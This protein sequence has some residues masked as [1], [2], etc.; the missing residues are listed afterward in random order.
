MDRFVHLQVAGAYSFLWGTFTP[1]ALVS[2]VKALGQRAVA[3]TDDGLYGAVRFYKAARRAGIQPIIGGR[4]AYEPGG[5]LTLLARD[6]EGY[7]HLCRMLSLS[8]GGSTL[9]DRP[10]SRADLGRL[11]RGLICLAGG[12]GT[13]LGLFIERG[14][15]EAAR[16]A[17]LELRTVFRGPRELF[18]VVQNYGEGGRLMRRSLELASRADLPPVAT[19]GVL[20]LERGDYALHRVLVRIQRRHHHREVEP[21]P[22]DGFYLAS[23]ETMGRL[24]PEAEALANTWRIAEACKGFSL[25]TGRLHPPRVSPV[26]KDVSA[27]LGRM[28]FKELAGRFT[29]TAPDYILQLGRELEVIG[30][31]DLADFFLLVKGVVDFAREAG[32]RHSVRGSAAGSLVVHLLL[33]GVDPVENDLLFE[34]FINDGRGDMPDV[35]IDFDSE[36]RDEVLRHVMDRFAG[37]AAMVCTVGKFRSR[38]AVRLVARGLGYSLSEI[39]RLSECLPY[40]IRGRDLAGALENLPELEN[41]PLRDHPELVDLACRLMALP[42]QPSVHLGGVIIAPGDIEAWTPLGVSNKGFAV[43]QFDKNDVDDLGLLKLDLLGLRM[44]TAVG[45]AVEVLRDRGIPFDP[46]RLPLD[47]SKTYAL[48]Q[49]THSLGVF[50]VESPGQRSLLG[51]MAPRRFS[52]LVAEISLFRPGPVEGNMVDVYVRRRNRREPIGY[53]DPVLEPILAETYGVILFQ[54][55]VL[56]VVNRFAGLSYADADVFRRAM[57]KDRGS[58][59]MEVLRAAFLKGASRLGRDPRVAREVF[60]HVAAFAAYGFCKAHAASFAHITYQSAYLK[61]HY[62]LAFYIGLLNAGHVGSYPAYVIL[63]EARR[64]GIVVYPPDVNFSGACYRAENGG[65]RPPLVVVD[66]VGSATAG[67]IIEARERGFFV[68]ESDFAL[69]TKVSGRV[70]RVLALAGA[71]GSFEGLNF[72]LVGGV[73]REGGA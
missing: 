18:V 64:R 8:L 65:I 28:C 55:Q 32:I 9:P 72:K 11:S 29:V 73:Y 10:V 46:D 26:S 17:L 6:F 67:R 45:R 39:K 1:Q 30:R 43:G 24:I 57:T 20:F 14:Q 70:R 41:S 12:W 51:R 3:L 54:E 34:R 2:R 68:N 58:K 38:S 69:R 59:Q 27:A 7:G 49:S 47:D 25:P 13:G 35:D 40:A 5:P 52:D 66:N 62:P 53:L 42:F 63:N 48:L 37:R 21:C 19:G 44:H 16:A 71:F 4:V 61:A 60:R 33:G 31:R 50:Q 15:I 23:G 22:D 56:R 36:R